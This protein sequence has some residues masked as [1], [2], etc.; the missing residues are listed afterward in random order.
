MFRVDAVLLERRQPHPPRQP[1]SDRGTDLF[2]DE[3]LATTLE[4]AREIARLAKAAAVPWFSTSSLRYGAIG[5]NVKF[6]DTTGATVWGPGP[7]QPL[8]QLDLSW[9]AIHPIETL[10]TLM[11]TGCEEVTRMVGGNFSSGA[12]VRMGVDERGH[13][14][15]SPQVDDNRPRWR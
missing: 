13:H 7:F 10:Y 12:D 14:G 8:F 2:I 6:P 1:N 3:P 5:S 11:G 15:L 9:Y 4:D